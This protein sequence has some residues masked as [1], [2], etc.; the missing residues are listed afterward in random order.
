MIWYG[1]WI[2][3]WKT[4][5]RANFSLATQSI[6]RETHAKPENVQRNLLRTGFSCPNSSTKQYT[7]KS[8]LL[9]YR[10]WERTREKPKYEFDQLNIRRTTKNTRAILLPTNYRY[11][12]LHS[13]NLYFVLFWFLN[14]FNRSLPKCQIIRIWIIRRTTIVNMRIITI[15]VNTQI[16]DWMVH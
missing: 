4:T 5:Q 16:N 3:N 15:Q 8:K 12:P 13:P 6:A 10:K 7:I 9:Q 11:L 14:D 1:D 2:H